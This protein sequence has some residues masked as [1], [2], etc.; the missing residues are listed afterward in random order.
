MTVN[1]WQTVEASTDRVRIEF[2]HIGEGWNGDHDVDDPDDEPL[3][4]LTITDLKTKDSEF[5]GDNVQHSYCTAI[6]SD[7]VNREALQAFANELA[8]EFTAG[9]KSW[10]RRCQE[11]SWTSA[12]TI[13]KGAK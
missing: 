1:V 8:A 10:K 7:K 2:E 4:R 13:N 3:L 6:N 12:E 11:L 5:P 9:V